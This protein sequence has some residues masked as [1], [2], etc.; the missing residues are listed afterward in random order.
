MNYNETIS[1]LY[2][3]QNHGIKLGLKRISKILDA[4][5]NPQY[6]F[7]SIHIAGTN[8]KGSTAAAC[9]AIL[10][11]HGFS[12]GLFTSPHLVSFTERIRINCNEIEEPDVIRIA[13][14][15][16]KNIKE[17]SEEHGDPTFFEF[18]TAMAFFH[19]AEKNIEWAVVETG[20]GGRLDATNI[21]M[22]A[23]SVITP[24]SFDHQIFLGDT[25]EKIAAEKTG[26]IKENVPVVSGIQKKEV[27]FLL[28]KTA[29]EKKTRIFFCGSDFSPK[30][31]NIGHSA[32]SFDYLD[33]EFSAEG[34]Q[35]NLAGA[36]QAQNISVA[37]KTV[38]LCLGKNAINPDK[39]RS[40]I[41]KLKWPG[42]IETISDNPPF[43][44][45]AAHNPEAAETLAEYLKTSHGSRKIIL[46]LGMMADK[47]ITQILKPLLPLS[48]R[49]IFTKPLTE[50]AASSHQLNS[51]A[52]DQ[53][54]TNTC[55]TD[56]IKDAIDLAYRISAELSVN[57]EPAPLIVATGS[58]YTIGEIKAALGAERILHDL[59]EKL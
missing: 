36:F 37:I 33:P 31:L 14:H 57:G 43:I 26:I 2:G 20:M 8:G 58:F 50:R 18:V 24:I 53:G 44:L 47:D 59:T 34:I 3:L 6:Q 19:F 54:Y 16:R 23:A 29:H 48:S 9:D 56:N 41:S 51:A 10:R 5:G 15:I 25:I 7:R 45:D 22:P 13:D 32:S 21:L 38:S 42:R 27:S 52:M 28:T 30:N 1:F 35:L 4:L 17:L 49:T 11:S 12:T 55:T 39:A 40:A 46:I